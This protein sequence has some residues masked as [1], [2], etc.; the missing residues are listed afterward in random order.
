MTFDRRVTD[1]IEAVEFLRRQLGTDKVIVLAESMGTLTGLPLVKRRP[2]LFRALVVT[3]LYVDM[4]ANEARKYH[5]SGPPPRCSS[6]S[7]PTT[8]GGWA[9]ASRS[10]SFCSKARAM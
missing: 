3:D 5:S 4:A 6:S 9:P 7:R 10:R 1:A 2:D 8:P